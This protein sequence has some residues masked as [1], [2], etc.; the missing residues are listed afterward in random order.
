MACDKPFT[1]RCGRGRPRSYCYDCLPAV[2]EVGKSAYAKRWKELNAVAVDAYNESRRILGPN[3]FYT[4]RCA[5]CGDEFQTKRRHAQICGAGRCRYKGLNVDQE[6]RAARYRNNNHRR[7]RNVEETPVEVR[8]KPREIKEL[9]AAATHC[10]LCGVRMDGNHPDPTSKHLDHVI[11]LSVGGLHT[12]ENVRVVCRDCNQR[13][14]SDG[15]DVVGQVSLW[16]A[17]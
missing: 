4:K 5:V 3:G 14:P 15:S 12:L 7:R 2:G 16:A 11:P 10:P 8:L 9:I 17:A 1:Q 13:R 6:L